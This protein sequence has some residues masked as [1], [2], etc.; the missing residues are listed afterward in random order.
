LGKRGI[1][2]GSEAKNSGGFGDVAVGIRGDTDGKLW[3]QKRVNRPGTKKLREKSVGKKR[4]TQ[5]PIPENETPLVERTQ[6][7]P[8]YIELGSAKFPGKKESQNKRKY[9]PF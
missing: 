9:K 8:K 2:R 6:G 5:I 7:K 1:T 3:N 4:E